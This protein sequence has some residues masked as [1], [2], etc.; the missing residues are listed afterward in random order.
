MA[1]KGGGPTSHPFK[2]WIPACLPPLPSLPLLAQAVQ[3]QGEFTQPADNRRGFFSGLGY[4]SI[5]ADT[6][7]F[8]AAAGMAIF[9]KALPS[10][11]RHPCC[12]SESA[13][14]KFKLLNFQEPIQRNRERK[15]GELASAGSTPPTSSSRNWM[16][17][18]T[19]NTKE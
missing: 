5:K 4:S 10:M 14:S 9:S 8:G 18:C 1:A 2:P 15:S 13:G 11:L 19:N 7:I 6:K 17:A 16:K 3:L 12:S